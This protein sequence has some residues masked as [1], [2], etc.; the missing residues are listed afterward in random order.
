VQKSEV[1]QP[2]NRPTIFT[3]LGDYNGK[4]APENEASKETVSPMN[5]INFYPRVP[6]SQLNVPENIRKHS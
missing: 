3:K 2:L 5:E 1:G 4:N 6:K